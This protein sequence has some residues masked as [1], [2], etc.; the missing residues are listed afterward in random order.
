[1]ARDGGSKV[2]Q[3]TVISPTTW[4]HAWGLLGLWEVF[5]RSPKHKQSVI[6]LGFIHVAHWGVIDRL[7]PSAP[8]CRSEQLPLP[9]IVFHSNYNGPLKEYLE[10]F[11]FKVPERMERIWERA[12]RWPGMKP[13]Q[14]FVEFVIDRAEKYEQPD[15]HYYC[16]YPTTTVKSVHKALRLRDRYARFAARAHAL[17]PEAFAREWRAFLTDAQLDL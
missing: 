3:V 10:M 6:D 13:V 15:A 7:P 12:P 2:R 1:M 5:Q 14:A 4:P 16:A 9:Y 17:E 8:A 11:A